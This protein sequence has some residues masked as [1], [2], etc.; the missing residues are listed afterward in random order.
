MPSKEKNSHETGLHFLK[1]S[2]ASA[3]HRHK[4]TDWGNKGNECPFLV[5]W[6]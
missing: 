5:E 2:S 3:T 1:A 4:L 6:E